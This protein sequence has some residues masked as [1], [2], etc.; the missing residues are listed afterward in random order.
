MGPLFDYLRHG[1]DLPRRQLA[2]KVSQGK[3][4]VL[5]RA[6]VEGAALEPFEFADLTTSVSYHSSAPLVQAM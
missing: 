6:E 3:M 2:V 4:A 5:K 1:N